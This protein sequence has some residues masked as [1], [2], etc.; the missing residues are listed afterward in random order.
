MRYTQYRGLA[1]ATNWVKLRSAAM[2]LEKRKE[3]SPSF[4]PS[5]LSSVYAGNPV[6]IFAQARFL[7]VVVN[8]AP[9]TIAG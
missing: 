3:N 6:C 8:Y 4:L 5:A 7:G 9:S 2:D 1:Q